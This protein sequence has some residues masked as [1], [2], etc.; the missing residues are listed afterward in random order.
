MAAP[1]P[2]RLLVPALAL[3]AGALALPWGRDA[4]QAVLGVCGNLLACHHFAATLLPGREPL[5]SRY[6]RFDFGH[7]PP[8]CAG[9]TRGLTLLWAALLAGF[10]AAQAAAAAGVLLLAALFVGWAG[11]PDPVTVT[12]E[13]LA[14]AV[15]GYTFVP[16]T[17]KRLAN[18]KIGVGTLMTIA[19]VGAVLLGHVD[20]ARS[21]PGVFYDLAALRPGDRIGVDRADG[22]AVAFAVERVERYP[23]DAF[24]TAD[25]Y[26]DLPYP[27][28]RLI[29][30]GGAFSDGHYLDNVVVY[31]R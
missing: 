23:K 8:D 26:G 21:G 22:G 18:G 30:C 6:T 12:L 25:V 29:T 5:I 1:P 13:A 15:A 20:S 27:G 11:G 19:A 4:A 7:L 10:A 2:A 31:A 28:L 9:Y 17:L 14:L 24:P 3:A 16:S